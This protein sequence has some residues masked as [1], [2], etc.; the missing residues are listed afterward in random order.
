MATAVRRASRWLAATTGVAALLVLSGCA[1]DA[2]LDTLEPKGPAA[3]EIDSLVNIVFSIAGIVFVFV[4][5]GVLIV[6]LRFRRKGDDDF[7]VQVHGNTKLEL[8][9]T[10]LPA[11]V[12]AGVAVFTVATIF[13]LADT[14]D[15]AE[16]EVRVVGQQWWW[17]FEYDLDG[18][19][20]FGDIVTANEMVVPAGQPISLTIASNDV[21][22]SFW[23]PSLN[24]KKDAVP[25]R[26]HPL[27]IEADEPGRY[28]G[29]CTEFCG[30]SHANMRMVVEAVSDGDFETWVAAQQ[31]P[32][33]IP[34]DDAAAMR[35]LETFVSQCVT[36][37]QVQG[38]NSPDCVP[39]EEGETYVPGETCWEGA[40]PFDGA[41]QVS[42]N[43][44]ELTHL[45][46]R[47]T[48]AGSIFDLYVD[49]RCGDPDAVNRAQLEAW[50]RN[51]PA[52]KAMA[53]DPNQY[54]TVGRG[55]PQLPLSEEQIDDLVAYLTTL[56]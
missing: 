33:A 47:C 34:E 42:G 3:R 56:D 11:V 6:A 49:E 35:G 29:Q 13:N 28:L 37:H 41:A 52:E 39:L 15:D 22:H 48:F 51:P 10:I 27:W 17:S 24:G 9:W 25:G 12:L 50:I 16:L 23:I 32:A 5:V 1:D 14:P 21:I 40:Q 30:L 18:D 2:P 46:S 53:P 55:M 43:A 36:C 38:V 19:G 8:G 31:E 44:P 26:E 4:T 20:D 45:M 7:P 54:T